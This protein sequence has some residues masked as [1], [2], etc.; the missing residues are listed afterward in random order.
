M[1][2]FL[3]G[4][5]SGCKPLDGSTVLGYIVHGNGIFGSIFRRANQIESFL[6]REVCM[7]AQ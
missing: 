1:D 5:V 2:V 4:C 7:L 6:E 3:F